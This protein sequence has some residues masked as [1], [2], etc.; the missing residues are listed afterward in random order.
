[1]RHRQFAAARKNQCEQLENEK[2]IVLYQKDELFSK[3]R[4]VQSTLGYYESDAKLDVYKGMAGG[5]RRGARVINGGQFAIN[6]TAN[7]AIS[8]HTERKLAPAITSMRAPFVGC[9]RRLR[10]C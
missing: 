1:M 10:R 8:R 3:L 4:G 7:F 6:H 9:H 5:G 2:N